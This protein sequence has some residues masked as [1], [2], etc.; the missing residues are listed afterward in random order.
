MLKKVTLLDTRD[1]NGMEV[2]QFNPD[3]ILGTAPN[4]FVCEVYKKK[5]EDVLIKVEL[6]P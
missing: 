2:F 6:N 3:R 1:V 4:T 5:K